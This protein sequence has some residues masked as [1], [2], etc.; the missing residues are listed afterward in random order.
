VT[1]LGVHAPL[2]AW[3][4]FWNYSPFKS[5]LID[6]GLIVIL[7]T[8][9]TGFGRR[10]PIFLPRTTAPFHAFSFVPRDLERCVWAVHSDLAGGREP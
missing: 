5:L 9:A 8:T 7:H 4:A 1:W 2:T 6:C 10:L 3:I